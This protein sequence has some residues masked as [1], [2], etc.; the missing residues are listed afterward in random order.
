MFSLRPNEKYATPI[1]TH[2][3]IASNATTMYCLIDILDLRVKP[4][5]RLEHEVN[6]RIRE[7]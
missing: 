1:I 3:A 5:P 4:S 6:K 7:L 2:A